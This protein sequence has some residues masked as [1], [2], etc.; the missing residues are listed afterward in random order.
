MTTEIFTKYIDI[1]KTCESIIG[2]TE[3]IES[4]ID[5]DEYLDNLE[6]YEIREM[7]E[8]IQKICL[9][10][11]LTPENLL[12]INDLCCDIYQFAKYLPDDFESYAIDEAKYDSIM[13]A[14][15]YIMIDSANIRRSLNLIPSGA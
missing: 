7:A 12:D 5:D 4:D 13:Y 11:E 15:N 14:L 3:L 1:L 10:D 2:N 6:F 9:T 8:S